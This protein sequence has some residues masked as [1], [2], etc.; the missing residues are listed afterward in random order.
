MSQA[1]RSSLARWLG[2]ESLRLTLTLGG[3]FAGEQVWQTQ[4]EKFGALGQGYQTRVQTDFGGVLPVVRKV[5][6]SR[7]LADGSSLSY[8]ESEGRNKPHFE[9]FF[10]RETALTTLRHNREEATAPLL[11]PHHDPVS[12]VMALRGPDA[13]TQ[14][15]RAALTGGTVHV[16]PLPDAEVGGQLARAFYLRPGGAY[17]ASETDAPYRLLR[18]VQPTDFGPVDASLQF[19]T[20]RKEKEEARPE[21]LDKP[22]RRRA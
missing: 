11:T 18:L 12:L 16:Q 9:T 2:S 5:Q 20:R 8:A 4:P 19:E 17:V 22:R 3:R 15:W 21:K 6:V 7:Y 14:L 1:A 10:D 13:P